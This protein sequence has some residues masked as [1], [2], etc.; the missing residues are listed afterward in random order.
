MLWI[1]G[2]Q[3]IVRGLA[4]AWPGPFS[5]AVAQQFEHVPWVGLH[6]F[7]VIWTLF[8]FM[9]G[10]SLSFSI[11][12]RRRIDQSNRP[13]YAPVSYTHLDVYKRQPV[14]MYPAPPMSAAS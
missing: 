7:D 11:A 2:G 13:I 9:V 5:T 4:K 6:L 12:S 10:I 1:I 8:M 14:K 3:D